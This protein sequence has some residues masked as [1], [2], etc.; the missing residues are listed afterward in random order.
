MSRFIGVFLSAGI[1]V[2]IL[3]GCGNRQ[4]AQQAKREEDRRTMQLEDLTNQRTALQAELNRVREDK[5]ALQKE[6][7]A[8]K[9]QNEQTS[10]ALSRAATELAAAQALQQQLESSKTEIALL[11]QKLSALES[12]V[13]ASM[14][15]PPEQKSVTPATQPAGD[16]NK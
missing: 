10:A 3:G 12:R 11:K 7:S 14:A 4:A 13:A 5:A 1:A 2:G 6:L 15:S 8:L 9:L 16:L